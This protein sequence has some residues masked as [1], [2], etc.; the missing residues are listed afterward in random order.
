MG[1]NRSIKDK[2]LVASG[3]CCAIC[4]KF[5]GQKIELHHI[6][7]VADGGK[8]TFDNCIPLCF[9][10]HSDMGKIDKKHPKGTQYSSQE[11]YMHRDNWYKQVASGNNI[12]SQIDEK[13]FLEDKKLFE[14]IN[15]AFTQNVKNS[16]CK[17]D[18][19]SKFKFNTFNS[20]FNLIDYSYDPNNEFLNPLLEAQRSELFNNISKFKN[21]IGLN[22]FPEN[23]L[24][25]EYSVTQKWIAIHKDENIRIDS[26]KLDNIAEKINDLA[27]I[28]WKSYIEFVR[29]GRML[30]STL[31]TSPTT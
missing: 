28:I 26:S 9:D 24:G 31:D 16:L 3:R 13:V 29:V 19:S 2:V 22:T 7:Q 5:C 15:S 1:F 12:Y 6:I 20:I 25:T 27:D 4:H 18:L 10:C 8:N 11:L 17:E 30:F 14:S 23:I 21:Y